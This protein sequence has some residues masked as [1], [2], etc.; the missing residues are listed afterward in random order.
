MGVP[1]IGCSC[2]V[3]TSS[4]PH[5]IRLRSSALITS[6]SGKQFL[7]DAGPDFRQQALGHLKAPLSAVLLTHPHFDHIGGLDDLRAVSFLRKEPL[8]CILSRHTLAEIQHRYEYLMHPL[9]GQKGELLF[10]ALDL[11]PLEGDFGALDLWGCRV[12]FL[13]YSQAGMHVTGFRL[14]NLAYVCDIR[15]Y[16]SAVIQALQGVETL[17]VSALRHAPSR[18]HFGIAEAIAFSETVGAKRTYFTHIAHDLDARDA[19]LYLPTNISLAWDGME[20]SFDEK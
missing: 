1:V 10:H 17:I 16:S 5:N 8:P 7:I 15:E 14:G 12:E 11:R 19:S 13:S 20:I 2:P 6:S 18:M 4:H 9:R 3:C